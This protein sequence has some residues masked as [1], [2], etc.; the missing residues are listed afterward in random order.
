[1]RRTAANTAAQS[2]GATLTTSGETAA[3]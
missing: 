3:A 2:D 1:V